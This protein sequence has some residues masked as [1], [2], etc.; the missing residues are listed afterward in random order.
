MTSKE[1]R[2]LN[3]YAEWKDFD[4]YEDVKLYA[5]SR[6]IAPQ[7]PDNITSQQKRRF[8]EKFRDFQVGIRN[9]NTITFYDIND[10]EFGEEKFRQSKLYYNPSN[11]ITI[12]VVIPQDEHYRNEIMKRI[13][14][15]DRGGLGVG[16]NS[17]YAKVCL[18]YLGITRQETR[19]FL[20]R[21]GN[22]QIT[23]PYIKVV[24]QPILAKVPNE[25]WEM[26][27]LYIN[28]YGFSVTEEGDNY[29]IK[30]QI[31]KFN[32]KGTFRYILVAVDVFSKKVMA[33]GIPAEYNEGITLNGMT[34]AMSAI[35]Y[36]LKVRRNGVNLFT[37]PH[38]L[39]VDNGPE[40]GRQFQNYVKEVN[41]TY[42]NN[43]TTQTKIIKTRTYT[44]NVNGLVERLNQEVRKKI[45]SGVV[46]HNRDDAFEWVKYL[47]EYVNN[48]NNSKSSRTGLT[49]NELWKPFYKPPTANLL[50]Y[51]NDT[52]TDRTNDNR[53]RQIV[54]SRLYETALEQ[55]RKGNQPYLFQVGDRVRIKIQSLANTGVAN[56]DRAGTEMRKRIKEDVLKKYTVITYTPEI[57]TV[58]Q[59]INP[60]TNV[61]NY[62][63]YNVKATEYFIKDENNVTL[64]KRFFGSDLLLVPPNSTDASVTNLERSRKLNLFAKYPQTPT[65]RQFYEN[66]LENQEEDEDDE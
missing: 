26:D 13:Y 56:L 31:H 32:K 3:A 50:Q 61:P 27:V 46:A 64:K 1:L 51:A 54:Q 2:K 58:T 16:L 10:P 6:G 30:D 63:N 24:N 45:R 25:R 18:D 55:I 35:V 14:E 7:Y 62:A 38:L 12:E 19:D 29:V 17:F 49:P 60:P 41:E 65:P 57:F 21:Q 9:N 36:S 40:F 37:L 43:L 59:I 66:Y 53:I 4:K 44:P 28:K 23:R 22:Y 15:S 5:A 34:F 39:Q 20:K 48:I 52:I 8:I 33:S 11:R 42:P 47:P